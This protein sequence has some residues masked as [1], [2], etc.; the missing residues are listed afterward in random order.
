[1][2]N[3]VIGLDSGETGITLYAENA[4]KVEKN[5]DFPKELKISEMLGQG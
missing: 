1:M 5:V 2:A 3:A 4:S